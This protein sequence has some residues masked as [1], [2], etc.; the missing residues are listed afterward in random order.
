ME[1][2]VKVQRSKVLESEEMGTY[3]RINVQVLFEGSIT[4]FNEIVFALKSH[5]K[6]FF[7]PEIEIRVTNRRN[8]TTIRTTI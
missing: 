7:I 6:Y 2:G 3:K 4:A 1:N 8:P 5:Q